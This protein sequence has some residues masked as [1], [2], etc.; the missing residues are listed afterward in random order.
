MLLF[1]RV[2]HLPF[3]HFRADVLCNGIDFAG[4]ASFHQQWLNRARQSG[5][6]ATSAEAAQ[7]FPMHQMRVSSRRPSVP[8][9]VA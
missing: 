1:G 8:A 2:I 9:N 4:V 5:Q 6:P 7:R 3:A